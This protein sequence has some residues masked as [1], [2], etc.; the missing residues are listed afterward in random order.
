MSEQA[1]RVAVEAARQAGAVM[2]EALR[3]HLEV[4]SKSSAIDLVTQVDVQC[5]QLINQIL[6]TAFPGHTMIGEES[7][8]EYGW[9]DEQVATATMEA[10]NAW[11]VDPIDGTRNYVQ[12]I[13]GF[14][15]SIA[16]VRR[17]RVELGVVYDPMA[18]EIFVARR[19]HGARCNDRP[20]R[21]ASV[22]DLG[23]AVMGTAFPSAPASR[24]RATAD[25]AA[26]APRVMD[27]RCLGSAALDLAYVACGRLT[28]SCD[29][30]LHSWDH[31]AGALLVEE[32]GGVMTDAHGT[33]YTPV[34]V[35]SIA[36]NG[37]IH[38]ALLELL[39]VP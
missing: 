4:R 28:G 7:A 5:E 37:Q 33:P 16:L 27:M 39:T 31:A 21:V 25:I 35:D 11:I 19:G 6:R 9:T 3:G 36:S 24:A 8:A 18:D 17:G 13:S 30:D 23:M 20:I 14:T 12:R 32:A 1:E 22:P 29:L 10:E 34:S 26:I 2:R 15:C 38:D